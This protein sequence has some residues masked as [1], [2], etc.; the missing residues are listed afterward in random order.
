MHL[1]PSW[2]FPSPP[3]QLVSS[4]SLWVGS[5]SLLGLCSCLWSELNKVISMDDPRLHGSL[6]PDSKPFTAMPAMPAT[7]KRLASCGTQLITDMV[8]PRSTVGRKLPSR[9]QQLCVFL[10][11]QL[12]WHTRQACTTGRSYYIVESRIQRPARQLHVV[13]HTRND[14]TTSF[15]KIFCNRLFLPVIQML[16]T[17]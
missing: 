3:R 10:D 15:G 5:R 7:T 14:R 2:N 1:V 17:R 9:P 13:A 11:Y 6:E 16:S 4:C 12:F 8:A